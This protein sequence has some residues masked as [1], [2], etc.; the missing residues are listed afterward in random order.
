MNSRPIFLRVLIALL[1]ASALSSYFEKQQ[2]DLLMPIRTML[3]VPNLALDKTNSKSERLP[4]KASDDG[5]Y[6]N[7][8]SVASNVLPLARSVLRDGCESLSE[9]QRTDLL[10]VADYF[11]SSAVERNSSGQ[12]FWVWTFP[13]HFTYGLTP[14]WVSGM[15]QAEVAVVM[16]AA[17]IC[18]EKAMQNVF[19]DA[20]KKTLTS[21]EIPVEEGGVLVPIAGGYWYEE[22]AQ[23][24][25]K[26]P[27]VLNGH[28]IAL[29]A[30]N[31][32]RA[33]DSRAPRLVEKGLQSLKETLHLYDA[34]TWSYYDRAG[35]PANNI[36]QQP[37]HARQMKKLYELTGDP[38]FNNYHVRFSRQ[39]WS[40]FS[41]VQRLIIKPT[42]FLFIIFVLDFIIIFIALHSLACYRRKFL[43]NRITLN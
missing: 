10:Y 25:V 36:Y 29:L 18:A 1:L 8:H 23:P 30:I 27:L 26:P 12:A 14:G 11:L 43:K 28:V 37:L 24:S 41:S 21:L 34:V 5:Y 17:S 2:I 7:S 35:H 39:L 6:I 38:I 16:A 3:L 15:V 13:I 9:K 33:W 31:D 20:A 19:V 32:L 22:Y 4:R 42:R 40:P